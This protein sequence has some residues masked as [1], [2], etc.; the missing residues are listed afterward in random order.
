MGIAIGYLAGTLVVGGAPLV[1]VWRRD[2]QP[3]ALLVVRLLVGVGVAAGLV[4]LERAA[5]F[6]HWYEPLL[7]VGFLAFWWLLGYR[8]LRAALQLVR[9]PHAGVD[10][11]PPV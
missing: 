11:P 9:R 2:R 4:V 1:V 7:V 5:G 6:S 3:W 10:V 8:D